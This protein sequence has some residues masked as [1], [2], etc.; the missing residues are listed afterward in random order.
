MPAQRPDDEV[1]AA[2]RVVADPKNLETEAP[3]TAPEHAGRSGG[4][5]ATA[6]A[7]AGATSPRD[8]PSGTLGAGEEVQAALASQT[9]SPDMPARRRRLVAASDEEDAGDAQAVDHAVP[10]DGGQDGGETHEVSGNYIQGVSVVGDD[11]DADSEVDKAT[12]VSGQ[13]SEE[14]EEEEQDGEGVSA[15]KRKKVRLEDFDDEEEFLVAGGDIEEAKTR[16][17]WG[18]AL[19]AESKEDDDF[20]GIESKED[21]SKKA[22]E[23]KRRM[24]RESEK[25]LRDRNALIKCAPVVKRSFKD[26][27]AKIE[28]RMSKVV[29]DVPVPN[30][31]VTCSEE[32]SSSLPADLTHLEVMAAP[33]QSVNVDEDDEDDDEIVIRGNTVPCTPM[34]LSRTAVRS[35]EAKGS[36][37]WAAVVDHDK[38]GQEGEQVTL[39]KTPEK[40]RAK[41]NLAPSKPQLLILSPPEA[42]KK[43]SDMRTQLQKQARSRSEH[44]MTAA[45]Q[46]I[47]VEREAPPGFSPEMNLEALQDPFPNLTISF[48]ISA[49]YVGHKAG[50]VFKMD[51]RGLGYYKEQKEDEDEEDGEQEDVFDGVQKKNKLKLS[52]KD[53]EGL[54]DSDEEMP[55]PADDAVTPGNP[56]LIQGTQADSVTPV[57]IVAAVHGSDCVTDDGK[58]TMSVAE[59]EA[60]TVE[61]ARERGS[62]FQ[63]LVG[64][65]EG[66]ESMEKQAL[67]NPT[68]GSVVMAAAAVPQVSAPAAPTKPDVKRKYGQNGI[69]AML[70][71]QQEQATLLPEKVEGPPKRSTVWREPVLVDSDEE[72]YEGS[73]EQDEHDEEVEA[74]EDEEESDEEDEESDEESDDSDEEGE[75]KPAKKKS[76]NDVQSIKKNTLRLGTLDAGYLRNADNEMGYHDDVGI[77]KEDLED[78]IDLM[79]TDNEDAEEEEEDSEEERRVA[80]GFIE[81]AKFAEELGLNPEEMQQFF[82]RQREELEEKENERILDVIRGDARRRKAAGQEDSWVPN[83]GARRRGHAALGQV[84]AG[85]STQGMQEF[86]DDMEDGLE[87]DA[88]A[89]AE[90]AAE[91][92]AR[93]KYFQVQKMAPACKYAE[94]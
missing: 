69:A 26:L 87:G 49:K 31:S 62:I 7:S 52:S 91:R 16:K 85:F 61:K 34:Q 92:M 50:Y 93:L 79:D 38:A 83:A 89:M 59:G 22:L 56:M 36:D 73:D 39:D 65:E 46:G 35:T 77:A 47:K 53:V 68:P 76:L 42:R 37:Q 81:D 88:A 72:D 90:R 54:E 63:N 40:K 71:K 6:T 12:S 86:A 32:M 1:E 24:Y 15:D 18:L 33:S 57:T 11:V 44:L 9:M 20:T 4:S 23:E 25:R 14:D 64:I 13:S 60:E 78:G 27:R 21:R 3:S 51:Q 55:G 82:Q 8:E 80:E 45:R 48:I 43:R 84:P 29:E 67:A 58:N 17:E 41:D 28:A 30:A 66:R 70:R 2:S 10:D 19:M 94:M 75:E 74:E 5:T